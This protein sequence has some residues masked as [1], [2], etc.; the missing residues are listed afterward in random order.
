MQPIRRPNGASARTPLV[1]ESEGKTL[2]TQ[3]TRH[4]FFTARIEASA[5]TPDNSRIE[6][7]GRRL[8]P[9]LSMSRAIPRG[10]AW[11]TSLWLV[12]AASAFAA[13]GDGT[14]LANRIYHREDGETMLSCGTMELTQ[15]GHAPRRRG[16]FSYTRDNAQ[17]DF[18]SLIRFTTPDDI[19]GT[20]LLSEDLGSKAESQ[21]VY[22]PALGRSRRISSKRKGGRFVSSDLYYEDLQDRKVEED[23]HTILGT[24]A[25][26]GSSQS[27]TMLESIP[28]EKGN[29]AYSRRVSWVDE[30]TLIAMRI[31][32]YEKGGSKPTKQFKVEKYKKIDGYWTITDSTMTEL[33]SGHST[34]TR[35]HR[36]I[37]DPT[38]SA[39]FAPDPTGQAIFSRA[40]LEDEE[41]EQGY[42]YPLVAK[43]VP[44]VGKDGVLAADCNPDEQ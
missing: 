30:Q 10:L 26:P 28:T 11:L 16:L 17:N 43:Y 15:K 32:F 20:A 12:G 9:S 22:L 1:R 2:K 31:D 4:K 6:I 34:R 8:M 5:R 38:F 39:E 25:C 13:G 21:W 33:K 18:W 37:Y 42:R 3:S 41:R 29:S 44:G 27:C 40:L 23:K 19:A 14:D 36:V 7:L 35:L 24:E